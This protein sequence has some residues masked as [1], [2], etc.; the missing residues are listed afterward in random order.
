MEFTLRRVVFLHEISGKIVSFAFLSQYENVG[1]RRQSRV[2]DRPK[3]STI[4]F[5]ENRS[6]SLNK[7]AGQTRG[8]PQAVEI[9]TC[10]CKA[11][12]GDDCSNFFSFSFY[13]FDRRIQSLNK[14]A[15]QTRGTPEAVGIETGPIQINSMRSMQKTR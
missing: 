9:E 15:G 7:H 12:R 1:G 14:H 11:C 5:L 3:A 6:Q 10:P 4:F 2:S 13:F 8:T